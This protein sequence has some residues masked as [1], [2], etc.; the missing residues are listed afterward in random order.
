MRFL[1]VVFFGMFAYGMWA[2]I[3]GAALLSLAVGVFML[4]AETVFAAQDKA[5]AADPRNARPL[6]APTCVALAEHDC[7]CMRSR[8]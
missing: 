4:W 2:G 1:Q 3:Y 5:Y 8:F 6:A 7:E